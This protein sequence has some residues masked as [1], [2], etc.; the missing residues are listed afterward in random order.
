VRSIK[1]PIAAALEVMQNSPHVML[2]AAGAEEFA[3]L[4]GLDMV[5]P[6]YF[7]TERRFNQLQKARQ[8][9]S[10]A[11]SMRTDQENGA[12]AEISKFGTVGAVALDQYGNI[13]AGTS[14]GGMTNKK[15]GRI[16]DSPIIGAGTYADNET[17][18]IS[19]TG[20][21]EY[22]IRNVVAYQI[23]AQMEHAGKSLAEAAEDVVMKRLLNQGGSGGVIGLDR[24]G[25]VMMTFNSEGM[26]R[27]Y[28]NQ[29]GN[30]QVFIYG[31]E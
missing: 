30:P 3:M 28:I 5:E 14:T 11:T 21:G 26:Y 1:S 27:G 4:Q 29:P 6:G 17:C 15:F 2:S 20:H 10:G 31:D 22:F 19:S 7:Y 23:A 25:N 13:A 24:E 18:G 9:E 12:E 8:D 16:G